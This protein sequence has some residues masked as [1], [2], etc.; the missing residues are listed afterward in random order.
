MGDE[1][2][3]GNHKQVEGQRSSRRGLL[4]TAAAVAAGAVA[5]KAAG[6]PSAEAADGNSIIIGQANTG[7]GSTPLTVDNEGHSFAGVNQAS[8]S[9]GVGLLGLVSISGY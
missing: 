7:T 1:A 4:T 6:S 9:R 5:A 2:E 3:P 8:G